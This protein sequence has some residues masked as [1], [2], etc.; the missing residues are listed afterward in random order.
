VAGILERPDINARGKL[1]VLIGR[2]TAAVGAMLVDELQK[3]AEVTLVGEPTGTGS[4]A[5]GGAHKVVLPNSGLALRVGASP[6]DGLPFA[7]RKTWTAPDVAVAMLARDYAANRDPVLESALSYV[8]SEPLSQ[9]IRGA[10]L[11]NDTSEVARRFAAFRE[12]PAH[13]YVDARASLDSVAMFF[14]ERR[15][16]DRAIAVLELAVMEY[17]DVPRAH[18]NLSA[19]Y[20][21]RMRAQFPAVAERVEPEP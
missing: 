20:A 21:A 6:R 11:A 13:A 4:A 2:N 18:Y 7:D 14:L 5:Y 3:Y 17:P 8:A 9:Q 12:N 15:E 1:L 16:Y 19:A 10:M